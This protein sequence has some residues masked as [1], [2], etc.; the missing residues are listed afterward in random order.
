MKSFNRPGLITLT[1]ALASCTS[2][3]VHYHTLLAPVGQTTTPEKPV[4]FLIDVLPVGVPAQLDQPQLIVR[5][6]DSSIALLENERWTGPLSDELRSALSAELTQRLAT[7][8]VAGLVQPTGTPVLRI[9][10]QVR[11]FDAWPGKHT[12][13]E[14]DWSMGFSSQADARLVCSGHFEESASAGYSEMVRAQ[15]RMVASLAA[16]ITRNAREWTRPHL[17]GSAQNDPGSQCRGA[18]RP[19]TTS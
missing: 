2:A 3:P 12:R 5:R 9:K 7:Q 14:A 13:L 15:Q 11:R 10:L 8:D 16:D 4:H 1:L 6:G 17:R 19:A 18:N